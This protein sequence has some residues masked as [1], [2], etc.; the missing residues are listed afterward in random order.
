MIV[1]FLIDLG[2]VVAVFATLFVIREE[3]S[4]QSADFQSQSS[5]YL[6]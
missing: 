5:V 3:E 6:G 1:V 2:G 4:F